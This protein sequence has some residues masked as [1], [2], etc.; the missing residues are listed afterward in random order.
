MSARR[1]RKLYTAALLQF[2]SALRL[3]AADTPLQQIEFFESHIRPVLVASCYPCHG[4]AVTAPMGKLRVDSR[5]MLLRGGKSGPA[6]MPGN[7]ESS[8]LWRAIAYQ[9]SLKMPPSGK[10]PDAQIADF[11]AWI[12]MGA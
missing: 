2:L 4:P 7:P 11:A 12:K 1:K 3:G 5:E 10:L 6:I 9:E 8:R